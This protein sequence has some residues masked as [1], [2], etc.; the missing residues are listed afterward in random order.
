[1][2]QTLLGLDVDGDTLRVTPWIPAGLVN[3]GPRSLWGG[4]ETLVLNGHPW[5]GKRVTVVLHLPATRGAAGV[6][7]VV[8]R[9]LN[10]VVLT[11]DGIAFADL[12]DGDNRIDVVLG[13]ATGPGRVARVVSDVDYQRVFG[14]RTPPTPG[15]AVQG[16]RVV[17]S[18]SPGGESRGDV[19]FRVLRDGVVL[20][21][22]L[23]GTTTTFTDPDHRTTSPRSPCYAV[24]TS[25]VRSG[26]R[27]WASAPNCF[28][29]S[30]FERIVT[31][32]AADLD[33]TGGVGSFEHGL[34]HYE[35]WG[36]AGDSLT[37]PSFT[38][39]QTGPHLVQVIYGNGAGD[40]STGITCGVKAVTVLD[41][42]TV[43]GTGMVVMPQLGTW[44]R[45]EDSTFVSVDLVA[46]RRYR[47]VVGDDAR[48][49]N[50]SSRAHYRRF[51]G[52]TG[53]GG[54]AFNRV[55]IAELKVLAR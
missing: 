12:D 42:D 27:S 45:W 21:D 47:I 43:V 2:E 54:D 41:G 13:T 24:E 17:L 37:L 35:P 48:A 30:A 9:R 23:P 5:R 10:G 31:V 36:D 55:N 44:A 34:F 6:L 4:S 19:T 51:T 14:P 53:G 40:V 49:T 7:P 22:G 28:W 29:G 1:V 39:T 25:F 26:T 8:E 32:G 18:L 46:G 38:A 20:A 11:G 50:M 15:L 33:H 3:G 16:D 52:G